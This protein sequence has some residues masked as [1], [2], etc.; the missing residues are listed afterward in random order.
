MQGSEDQVARFSGSDGGRYC[1]EVAHFADENHVGVLA[2][3]AANRLCK[4]RHVVAD[5]ALRDERLRGRVVEFDRVLD[6]D[7]VDAALVVDD[8]EHRGE[9]RRL[10]GARRA[11]D[12]DETAR[13]EEKL[14]DGRRD[15]DLL[16]REERRRNLTEN[17]AV[18]L[19]FLEHR[20]TETRSVG[21]RKGE[22]GAAVLLDL[23]HLLVGRDLPHEIVGVLLGQR[24]VGER[25]QLAVDAEL[26]RHARA[27]VKVGTTFVDGG[28]KKLVHMYV[29]TFLPY[30]F[31]KSF[32]GNQSRHLTQFI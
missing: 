13:L 22:V 15:A 14:L 9:R 30:T 16:E 20:H 7:D 28:L 11:S 24:L 21:V 12:E 4:A 1:L 27:D 17:R 18:A 32:F 10:A 19:S 29:H 6:R 3:R 25:A 23:L 8:V 31:L 2:E 26:R 5:F